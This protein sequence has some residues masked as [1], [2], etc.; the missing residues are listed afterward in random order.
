MVLTFKIKINLTEDQKSII[1]LMSEESTNLYNYFLNK[2]QIQYQLDKTYVSYY[3]QQKEL[4]NYKTKYLIFDSKKEVLSNLHYNYKSFF[5][6]S[7]HNKNLNPKPPSFRGSNYFF[8]LNFNQGFIIKNDKLIISYNNRKKIEIKLNYIKPIEKLTCLRFKT[9]QS[10]IKQL[11]IYKKNNEYYASIIYEK[12]ENIIKS[13]DNILSIDLGKKNLL[14]VYDVKN[15]IGLIFSSKYLNKNQKF[16]DKQTDQ[17]KSKKNKK[18]KDSR[19]YKQI[20]SKLQKIQS[21]KKTQTNLILQKITKDLS[22]QN[23]TILIGKLD[24]LKNNIKTPIKSINRQMQNNWNLQTFI[25]L[26]EYKNKLKGNQVIKV[27]EAWTSK[28]CCNCNNINHNLTLNDRQYICDCGVNLNR[29]INGAIN[30][31]KKFKG[32]YNT[33]LDINSIKISEKFDWCHANQMN[34]SISFIL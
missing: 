17:L 27:N 2:L 30:I 31:Y 14:S 3:D 21:K 11:K 28:K 7:K 29:D 24:N 4:K 15:N 1:D 18:Q 5:K 22:N 16:L 13:I 12:Q 23:K 8:T 6:L 33:P 19:K 32:D 20:S 9:K 10:D 26:L 34:K 25:H